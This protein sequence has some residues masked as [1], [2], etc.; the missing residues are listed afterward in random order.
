MAMPVQPTEWTVEMV[1]ALPDDGNRYEVVDGELFV[2]PAPSWTHQRAVAEL[3]LI[4]APY[5]RAHELGVAMIAP[6][7][8]LFGPRN[9]V[10]PDLFVVPLVNG[11]APETWFAVGRLLL[12]V[13]ISPRTRRADRVDKRKLYQRKGVPEY[14]V[15]DTDAR[16]VERWRPNEPDPEIFAETLPWH[17]DAAVPPLVIDLPEYFDRVHGRAG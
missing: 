4:L 6:A 16:T 5:L 10:E 8:I 17:P 2:T 9:A 15:V 13:V 11:A 14:W 12:V 7:D 3:L 1:R